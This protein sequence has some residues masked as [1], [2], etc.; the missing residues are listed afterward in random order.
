MTQM[1]SGN[2]IWGKIRKLKYP[3]NWTCSAQYW[4]ILSS[5]HNIYLFAKFEY[6]QNAQ[7]TIQS[8]SHKHSREI[9]KT[10]QRTLSRLT[11]EEKEK[12][13]S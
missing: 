2:E 12:T 9:E 8:H 13:L 3:T 5:W 4:D 7:F 6:W 10:V 1:M 11:A